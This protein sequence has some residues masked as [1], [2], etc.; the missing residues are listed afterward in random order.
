M[1]GGIC[2]TKTLGRRRTTYF[3]WNQFSQTITSIGDVLTFTSP[4]LQGRYQQPVAKIKRW[5]SCENFKRSCTNAARPTGFLRAVD[6]SYYIL[7]KRFSHGANFNLL[8]VVF[9][10]A[11]LMREA[12]RS[13]AIEAGWRL[14]PV[15]EVFCFPRNRKSS[16]CTKSKYFRTLRMERQRCITWRRRY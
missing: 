15:M 10:P 13:V 7:H 16:A 6:L 2:F 4:P 3:C 8:G 11:F 12:A 14:Q 1:S 9:D 5:A